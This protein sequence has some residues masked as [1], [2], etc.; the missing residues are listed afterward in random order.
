NGCIELEN[1]LKSDYTFLSTFLN[2]GEINEINIVKKFINNYIDHLVTDDSDF[3]GHGTMVCAN[4]FSFNQSEIRLNLL[5]Y[6][7]A[8]YRSIEY[9]KDIDEIITKINTAI[10]AANTKIFDIY[11]KATP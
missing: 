3:S 10:S 4:I 9:F 7:A 11:N 6:G 5:K 8:K 2:S 1:K